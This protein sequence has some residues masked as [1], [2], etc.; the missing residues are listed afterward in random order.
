MSNLRSFLYL[1]TQLLDDYVASI[2]GYVASEATLTEKEIGISEKGLNAGLKG[3]GG[4]IEK[5]QSS[6]KETK[7]IVK[8]T[9]AAKFQKVFDYL[10][11]EQELPFYE[12]VDEDIF[13]NMC[14]EDFVEFM[15]AIRFTKL[16]EL[17]KGIEEIENL[18]NILSA[19]TETQLIDK[20][21][22]QGIDGIKKLSTEINKKEIPCVMSF[23]TNKKYQIVMYLDA[24]YVRVA[25]TSF[26][27][28]LTL[29]CKV[30]RKI[31]QGEKIELTD[32][33]Q[34]I[35][36]MPLSREQ[37]RSMPKNLN[38]PKEFSDIIY[39]PAILVTPIAIYR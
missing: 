27:G 17:S 16:Q 18:S 25:Q 37:R 9:D 2:Q 10:N 13:K 34:N 31:R 8:L 21:T 4:K 36:A 30:Q 11:L 33:F 35:K 39:G 32:I 19:F 20:K 7:S 1:N 22:Q 12:N 3:F 5:T 28:D 29:L 6:E 38:T 23:G 15:G 26:V 24:D 14:R